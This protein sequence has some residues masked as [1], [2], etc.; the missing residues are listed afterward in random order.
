MDK[1]KKECVDLSKRE[2]RKRNG[3]GK[4]KYKMLLAKKRIYDMTH[5][6]KRERREIAKEKK[7]AKFYGQEKSVNCE[8][9]K[10]REKEKWPRKRKMQNCVAIAKHIWPLA[11][12]FYPILYFASSPQ[13]N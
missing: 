5:E 7:N 3:Q 1:E 11:K 13:A 8:H 2:R 6:K 12:P 4:E 9:E 10:R